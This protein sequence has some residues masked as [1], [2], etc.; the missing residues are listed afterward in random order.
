VTIAS[1]PSGDETGEFVEMI[2]PTGKAEYFSNQGWTLICPTGGDLPDGQFCEQ[3]RIA[4]SVIF[5]RCGL[6]LMPQKNPESESVRDQ[7]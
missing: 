3:G 4:V 2:C 5:P 1:R 7:Q 6:I